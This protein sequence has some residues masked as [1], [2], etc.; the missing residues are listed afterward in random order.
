MVQVTCEDAG[1]NCSTVFEDIDELKIGK[2]CPICNEYL[3][4]SARKLLKKHS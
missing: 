4:T 3:D 1:G 2:K